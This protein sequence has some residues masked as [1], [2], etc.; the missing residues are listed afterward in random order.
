MSLTETKSA[1][2]LVN[3]KTAQRRDYMGRP[4]VGMESFYDIDGREGC[5]V[6]VTTGKQISV[7]RLCTR[8]HENGMVCTGYTMYGGTQLT[9]RSAPVA[10][11]T[12]K[13]AEANHAAFL[14]ELR[15]A[16]DAGKF[17]LNGPI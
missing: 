13:V 6:T 17:D 1:L 15:A 14:I 7:A 16:I 2:S 9:K 4:E 11:F 5:G 3:E 8:K 10:R 12:Q